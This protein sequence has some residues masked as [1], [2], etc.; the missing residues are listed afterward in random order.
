MWLLVM[1]FLLFPQF[2]SPYRTQGGDMRRATEQCV[3]WATLWITL[4]L[5][6]L[7]TTNDSVPCDTPH[8]EHQCQHQRHAAISIVTF[9]KEG[10]GKREEKRRKRKEGR[11]KRKNKN[12]QSWRSPPSRDVC[13]MNTGLQKRSFFQRTDLYLGLPLAIGEGWRSVRN[14]AEPGP[15]P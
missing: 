9:S 6:M 10:R 1:V 5:N 15:H 7:Q 12:K 14:V 8:H 11:R 3:W 13:I 4:L 2:A